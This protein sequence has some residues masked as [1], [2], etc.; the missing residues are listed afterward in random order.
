MK[1]VLLAAG[2]SAETDPFLFSVSAVAPIIIQMALGYF[3]KRAGVLTAEFLKKANRICY[4]VF[5]PVLLFKNVYD[6][7][8]ISN[9]DPAFLIFACS[10]ILIVFAVCAVYVRFCIKEPDERGAL[11]QCSFRSN[12]AIIGVPLATSLY[13]SAGAAAASLMSAFSIPIF[14][15]LAIV[16]L[17]MFK[18][19]GTKVN[20]KKVIKEIVT[21]PLIIGIAV[22]VVFLAVREILTA[23]G[24]DFRLFGEWN[25]AEETQTYNFLGEAL[26][27]VAQVA[28]PLSL[29]VLG[30]QFE[31]SA[32]K[33]L[34]KYITVGVA[35]RNF[36]VPAVC[37]T[38][39]YFV[40]PD[41]KG[42][43]A[44]T[45]I[46]LFASPVAVSS[47]ILAMEMENDEV[48]AGQLVVWTT[49]ISAVSLFLIIYVFSLLGVFS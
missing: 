41:M 22:G 18:G 37:L 33:D 10:A 24:S 12:Y 49:V 38:A 1:N 8:S 27:S 3:L 34:A 42:E 35:L 30:G 40:F 47:A 32:V 29:V 31:F 15:V 13:G 6:V 26:K 23:N 43:Y 45:F 36:I 25:A 21:N 11:L 19:K 17:S 48:L 5:L 4:L 28:T 44:A 2:V 16:S 39:A 46:A 7:K 9:I 14:N 20:V